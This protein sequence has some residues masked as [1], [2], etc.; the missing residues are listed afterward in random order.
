MGANVESSGVVSDVTV[1][2]DGPGNIAR[3]ES[4]IENTRIPL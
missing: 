4:K 3:A 2:M 1:L